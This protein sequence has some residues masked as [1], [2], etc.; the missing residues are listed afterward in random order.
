MKTEKILKTK[1]CIISAKNGS[2]F[3]EW[4]VCE[5]KNPEEKFAAIVLPDVEPVK[6]VLSVNFKPLQKSDGTDYSVEVYESLCEL[7]FSWQN[8]YVLKISPAE[9]D[10]IL[11]KGILD[12]I[13]FKYNETENVYTKEKE[14]P[15]WGLIYL[16]LGMS[17]G[18]SLGVSM[19]NIGTGMSIGLLMGFAI[20]KALEVSQK[21][22]K[23]KVMDPEGW[24]KKN[25]K[26][27]K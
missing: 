11:M 16:C 12:R 23:E 7:L 21:S 8:V 9:E 5:K 24:E 19:T 18:L 26:K 2:F 4:E 10:M 1:N 3:K 14:M 25:K 20:G 13:G 22:E 27:N 15:M 17:V 6:G